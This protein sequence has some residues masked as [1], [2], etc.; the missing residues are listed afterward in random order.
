MD[1]ASHLLPKHSVRKEYEIASHYVRVNAGV[2]PDDVLDPSFWQHLAGKFRVE[3]EVTV[4]ALDGSFRL[5]ADVVAI[6]PEGHWVKLRPLQFVE[7]GAIV[8][9][10]KDDYRIDRDPVQGWRILR[11][12]DLI[13][14]DLPDQAAA[15]KALAQIKAD[16]RPVKAAA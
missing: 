13:E 12:R 2:T 7:G 9:G 8:T 11:G 3:D 10:A 4:R 14:K 1:I 16:K 15:E 6:D 5:V